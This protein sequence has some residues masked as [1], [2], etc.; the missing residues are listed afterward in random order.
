[1]CIWNA[2]SIQPSHPILFSFYYSPMYEF[3][4]VLSKHVLF[5]AML[6]TSLANY[7]YRFMF[8]L[9]LVMHIVAKHELKT[10]L[11]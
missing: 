9:L 8:G 5:L 4:F 11:F 1:M 6:L 3:N 2:S 7:F 10:P